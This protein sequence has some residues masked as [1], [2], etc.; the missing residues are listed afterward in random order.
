VGGDFPFLGGG[1]KKNFPEGEK[2][3]KGHLLNYW[4]RKVKKNAKKRGKN[5]LTSFEG[6]RGWGRGSGPCV[7][8]GK[9]REKGGKI[10]P[11]LP[12]VGGKKGKTEEEERVNLCC[13]REKKKMEANHIFEGEG[14]SAKKKGGNKEKGSRSKPPPPPSTKKNLY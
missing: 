6:E 4:K 2:K 1:K 3:G 9:K 12:T 5:L 13:K 14:K 11:P 7:R 10:K 8:R